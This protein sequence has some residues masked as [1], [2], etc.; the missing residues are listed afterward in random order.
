[1]WVYTKRV[2]LE[3]INHLHLASVSKCMWVYAKRVALEEIVASVCK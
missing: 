3:E 2:A 1:M